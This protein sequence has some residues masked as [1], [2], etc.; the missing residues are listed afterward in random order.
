[1]IALARDGNANAE[2][3]REGERERER[4]KPIDKMIVGDSLCFPQISITYKN[5]YCG[6]DAPSRSNETKL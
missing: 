4:A 1:M 6:G 3:E 2:R 5:N